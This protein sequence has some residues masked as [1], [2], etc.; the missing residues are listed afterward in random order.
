MSG[1]TSPSA[2]SV[3][4]HSTTDSHMT[5]KASTFRR[6]PLDPDAADSTAWE[7]D[8]LCSAAVTRREH[9]KEASTLFKD[10]LRTKKSFDTSVFGSRFSNSLSRSTGN[11]PPPSVWAPAVVQVN[12]EAAD[13]QVSQNPEAA[14]ILEKTL[15]S[16]YPSYQRPATPLSQNTDEGTVT[17]TPSTIVERHVRRGGDSTIIGIDPS[18][19]ESGF[20]PSSIPLISPKPIAASTGSLPGT[21]HPTPVPQIEGSLT[22]ALSSA[23][24]YLLSGTQSRPPSPVTGSPHH[25][26]LAYEPISSIDEHPHIKYDWTIGQRLKFSCTV[27]YAKQ[28]DT[29][30]KRCGVDTDIIK[31]LER[32]DNWTAVGGKSKSNFWKSSDD[33]FII[34]TLVNAWNVA[35]L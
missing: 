24:R 4:L 33:R 30:R 35:D 17:P 12:L 32:S 19:Q 14:D 23:V 34:K 1:V 25:K 6:Q 2:A 5:I 27:Y 31:S 3:A 15:G 26:L 13:G 9:P 22:S 16:R 10:V 21:R 28:F 7:D 18:Q 11:P 20:E 8:E 29:L